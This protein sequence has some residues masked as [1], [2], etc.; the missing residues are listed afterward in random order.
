MLDPSPPPG[1]P[2]PGL[3]FCPVEVL[4]LILIHLLPSDLPP[5]AG[6]NRHLRYAVKASCDHLF[7]MR[8]LRSTE[9]LIRRRGMSRRQDLVLPRACGRFDHPILLE[10]LVAAIEVYGLSKLNADKLWGKAR[11]HA[12]TDRRSEGLRLHR[13][14]AARTAVERGVWPARQAWDFG[15]QLDCAA[16]MAGYLRSMDL[17]EDLCLRFPENMSESLLKGPLHADGLALIPPH[18]NVLS[19][20]TASSLTLLDLAINSSSTSAVQAL[21]ELGAPANPLGSAFAWPA[22]LHTALSARDPNP[23]IVQLLLYHGADTE[24]RENGKTALHVAAMQGCYWAIRHLLDAGAD[25]RARDANDSTALHIAAQG[26]HWESVIALLDAGADANA[27]DRAGHTV[28]FWAC[29]RGDADAARMLIQRRVS[30]HPAGR[31]WPS[32]LHAAVASGQCEVVRVLVEAGANPNVLDRD[33][34]PPLVFALESR[35]VAA[36]MMLLLGGADPNYAGARARPPLHRL[37]FWEWD[38]DAGRLLA[39]MV[40]RGVDWTAR[41]SRG[42][43]AL[44]LAAANGRSQFMLAMWETIMPPGPGP[45]VVDYR[46]SALV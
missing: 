3:G 40:A 23:G 25:T 14:R 27:A 46:R 35:D 9:N 28:M 20:H 22:P 45:R 7:A 16:E 24:F 4:Q 41:D 30:V 6:S 39:A 26:A 15:M 34:R 37:V 11:T 33:G 1:P 5:L 2:T 10:H 44:E 42:M 19:R 38:A 12:G 29:H 13:V 32:P 36:A 43:T 17:F 21:L 31:G 18:H 8:H